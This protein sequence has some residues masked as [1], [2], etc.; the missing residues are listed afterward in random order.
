VKVDYEVLR[1]LSAGIPQHGPAQL[2]LQ[3]GVLCACCAGIRGRPKDARR[4]STLDEADWGKSLDGNTEMW[5][6]RCRA[7]PAVWF[8]EL[9]VAS[10][11]SMWRLS[12]APSI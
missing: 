11:S 4:H 1:R 8:V 7:C 3:L 10:R 12:D 2:P 5:F 9:D 6:Y